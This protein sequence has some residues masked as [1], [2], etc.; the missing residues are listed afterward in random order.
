MRHKSDLTPIGSPE[1]QDAA[2]DVTALGGGTVLTML[3]LFTGGYL[4]F[5]GRK[6][7]ALFV[8]GSIGSGILLSTILKTLY[9]RP[10]PDLV[11]HG[12]Y[13]ST[14]SFPSGHSM[15][16]RNNVSS[17]RR[18]TSK[19]PR[20]QTPEGV[21]PPNRR[22]PDDPNRHQPSLPKSTGPPTS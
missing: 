7:L 1:V 11:P 17:P 3:T 2:R 12:A 8:W 21:L 9:Q 22:V 10:R 20:P 16:S 15:L 6:H 4:F 18:I 19:S 13:V 14:A 5:D